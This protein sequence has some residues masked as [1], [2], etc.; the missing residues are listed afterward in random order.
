MDKKLSD[1]FLGK[2]HYNAKTISGVMGLKNAADIMYEISPKD[3][4]I[5]Q[6]PSL[7]NIHFSRYAITNELMCWGIFGLDPD[8]FIITN[9]TFWVHHTQID[10]YCS[11]SGQNPEFVKPIFYSSDYRQQGE[12]EDEQPDWMNDVGK[13]V[14]EFLSNIDGDCL[15]QGLNKRLASWERTC[16]LPGKSHIFL[17]I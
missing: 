5:I 14:L 1:Y 2:L 4:G 6:P 12:V 15:Y 7:P 13:L 16:H 11:L 3:L 8:I 17:L 9:P 10:L